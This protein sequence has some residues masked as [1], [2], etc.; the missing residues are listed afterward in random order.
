MT[1]ETLY[2]I[3][4]CWIYKTIMINYCKLHLKTTEIGYQLKSKLKNITSLQ[5]KWVHKYSVLAVL[6]NLPVFNIGY[7]NCSGEKNKR[8]LVV[9]TF[10]SLKDPTGCQKY[11][12]TMY[13]SKPAQI[14][15]VMFI[16]QTLT[17]I[18]NSLFWLRV[19]IISS[20]WMFYIMLYKFS[21]QIS[22]DIQH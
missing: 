7:Y 18:R 15:T 5:N 16:K 13:S 3:N 14:Y 10:K 17:H 12:C 19:I 22:S 11:Y 2:V 6:Y 21:E 4:I 8:Y 9:F 20:I 1:R